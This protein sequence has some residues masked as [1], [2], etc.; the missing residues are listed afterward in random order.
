MAAQMKHANSDY[1]CSA[2]EW[3]ARQDL[4]ACYRIFDHLGWSESIYN[5]IS[6]KVPGEDHAFLINPFGLLYSEVTA[7]NLVKIDIDGNTLDG[8]PHPVNKAGFTQH[9]YFHRHL[10]WAHAICHTH[11]TATM[12]VCA[13]E[14]G[15]LPTNFYACNF[16]GQI[17]YHDFEG[18]TVREE[19]GE[20]L[21]ANLG[22][23]HILMLRNHGPVVIGRTLPEMFIQFWALQRA[24]EIQVATMSMGVPIHVPGEVIGVHQRDLYQAQAPGGPGHADF[25]AW[26]RK[27]ARI[28]DSW[29]N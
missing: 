23:K 5:H 25:E 14:G 4:A 1:A 13:S 29:K 19:E 2:E 15:L 17:G 11:T 3:T 10:D 24:C 7:S 26:K 28:D 18:V 12:A 27:I 22:D 21:L 20:R 9:A 6:L 8:S 16:I